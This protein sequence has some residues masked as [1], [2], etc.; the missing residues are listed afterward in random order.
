MT[1]QQTSPPKAPNDEA[2]HPD[3][4]DMDD[5]HLVHVRVDYHR[6]DKPIDKR[7]PSSTQ[8]GDVKDWAMREFRIHPQPDQRFFLVDERTHA[9]YGPEDE[10]NTL[11]QLGYTREARLRLSVEHR[12]G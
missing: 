6:T 1:T 3:R 5:A 11:G 2:K 9:P 8:L 12:A 7:F 10:K 4:P